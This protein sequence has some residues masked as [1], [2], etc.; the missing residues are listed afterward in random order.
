MLINELKPWTRKLRTA[1][2]RR[3]Q[4]IPP[5]LA[6]TTNMDGGDATV[7]TSTEDAFLAQ[8]RNE[9]TY[10]ASADE[11][12]VVLSPNQSIFPNRPPALLDSGDGGNAVGQVWLETWSQTPIRDW[13][14]AFSA[15]KRGFRFGDGNG[16]RS[17]GSLYSM[18]LCYLSHVLVFLCFAAWAFCPIPCRF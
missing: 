14:K 9:G 15:G 8:W 1:S 17:L 2:R 6:Y 3:N 18:Y 12:P 13:K 4:N 5:D 10:L 11:A 16:S 7:P